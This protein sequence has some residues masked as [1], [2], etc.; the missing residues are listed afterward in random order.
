MTIGIVANLSDGAVLGADSAITITGRAELPQGVHQGVLKV[1]NEAEKVYQL[2]ELPIGIMSYGMAMMGKRTIESYVREFEAEGDNRE[3]IKGEKLQDV[4]ERLR[5][6]FNGKYKEIIGPELEGNLQT[7]YEEIPPNKKPLLGIVLAGYS[8]GESLS[9]VWEV[10]I[11]YHRGKEDLKNVRGRG[12]FGTNW[13]G[14]YFAITRFLK[15]FDPSLMNDVVGYFAKKYQIEV[16]AQVSEEVSQVIGKHEYRI[17]F[18]AMPLIE[19]VDHVRFLL[20]I[21]IN[22]Y[23]YVIGAPVCGGNIRIAVVT[24]KG[25]KSITPESRLSK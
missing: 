1:Y 19:G 17:P 10:Q 13:F 3:K 12:E 11:P 23:R 2:A 6:F 18:D 22:Q 15:G 16:D 21:V 5:G 14:Q 24:N 20:D 9:E 7:P 8:P 4:A 25:F